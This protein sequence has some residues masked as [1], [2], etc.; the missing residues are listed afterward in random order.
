MADD[1]EVWKRITQGDEQ[2]FEDF[3]RQT[4]PRLQAFLRHLVGSQEAAEDVAQETYTAMWSRLNGYKPE[5]GELR[6]YLYGAARR[7]AVDWWRKQSRTIRGSD[8]DAVE[9]IAVPSQIEKRSV[10]EDAFQRLPAEQRALLWLRE[11]EGQSYDELAA[12]LDIPTGTVRSRL[13][14]AREALRSIWHGE[15]RSV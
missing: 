6:A 12:I 10:V 4:A 11:V 9:D 14:A 8:G 7:Q 5:I 13:F 3:Y 2:A 15:R 1:R